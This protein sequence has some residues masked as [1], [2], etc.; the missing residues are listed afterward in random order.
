MTGTLSAHP[1]EQELDWRN[2]ARATR[3]LIGEPAHLIVAIVAMVMEPLGQGPATVGFWSLVGA[4]VLRAPVLIPIW[5]RMCSQ[6][7]VKLLIGWILWSALSIVWSPSPVIGVDRLWSLKTF[8]WLPLLWPLHRHWKWLLGGFLFATVVMQGIQ[9]SGEFF[10]RTYK[11]ISLAEGLRHPT[12]TGMYNGIA[13]SCWLFLSVSAG[14]R[15]ALLSFP[16]AALSTF[17]FFWANQRAAAIG[18][19]VELII[20]NIILAIVSKGWI[21]R[22]MTRGLIGMMLIGCV[23][24]VVG[25][26]LEAKF[27][28]VSREANASL[29]GD[30]PEIVESRIA[31]WK[32]SLAG[33]AKTPIIGVGLGGYRAAT[34][35]IE[36]AYKR[37]DI[38]HYET[39]HSTYI[40]ILTETGVI[41]LAI[42]L[43]WTAAFFVRAVSCLR[44]D[45]IRI[46][47]FGGTIIWYSAAATDS[48]HTRGAFLTIG[49]IMMALAAMPVSPRA[50]RV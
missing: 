3:D 5:R 50:Q 47:A 2:D 35:D 25:Q 10:H 39:P 26:R 46:G 43:L 41:G 22:A 34:A 33:W 28:Q 21:G 16:M 44:V 13:L 4:G 19:I 8:A 27:E 24:F 36:V 31:M 6:T 9:I 37:E 20:A 14:W 1:W 15:A 30:A 40:M 29:Q 11:G 42:F 38:H 17:G 48:F 7:W 18:I 45:T 12:M 23:Y 49:V 32:L